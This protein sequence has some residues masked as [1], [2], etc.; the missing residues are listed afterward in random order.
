LYSEGAGIIPQPEN[1]PQRR[2][3][4]A[5]ATSREVAELREQVQEMRKEMEALRAEVRRLL[6][7]ET[8]DR[9]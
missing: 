4:E 1:V 5:T 3:E 6:E 2:A 7:R 8:K 9:R